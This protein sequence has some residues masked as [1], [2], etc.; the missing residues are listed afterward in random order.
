MGAYGIA[1]AGFGAAGLFECPVGWPT[2]RL[3]Q[4]VRAPEAP[5]F[6]VT[7]DQAKVPLLGGG[8]WTFS[9]E[10]FSGTL[11]TPRLLD[12]EELQHPGLAGAA[13]VLSHWLGRETFHAGAF[14][15]HGGAWG[16]MGP[17]EAGKTTLLAHLH[18]LG[19]PVVSDDQLVVDAS[20]ML[21]MAGPRGLDLR[22]EAAEHLALE[23][24]VVRQ[25]ERRRLP[26]GDVPPEIPLRGWIRL[27]T[28]HGHSLTSV[29]PAARPRVLSASRT[30]K[31]LPS[32]PGALIRLADLPFFEFR[33]PLDWGEAS[34]LAD[35]LLSAIA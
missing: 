27:E 25:G 35:R 30:L 33:R 13:A 22:L 14:V 5:S 16:I 9:R 34:G 15:A 26:L 20:S 7:P 28:G 24:R 19:T 10:S 23:T 31:V 4:V 12:A 6:Q 1:I 17:K 18:L 32:D 21:V 8:M 3:R 29:P 11:T 2:A